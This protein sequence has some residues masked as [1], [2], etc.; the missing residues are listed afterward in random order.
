MHFRFL[1]H[2][3]PEESLKIFVR[4]AGSQRFLDVEFEVAA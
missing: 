4:G 3:L 2:D 1:I